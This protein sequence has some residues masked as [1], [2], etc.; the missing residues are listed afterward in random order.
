MV[1]LNSVRTE[2]EYIYNYTAIG[3]PCHR[4]IH[5]MPRKTVSALVNVVNYS[6]YIGNNDITSYM[7]KLDENKCYNRRLCIAVAKVVFRALVLALC[8]A[9]TIPSIILPQKSP[10]NRSAEQGLQ[11]G[12]VTVLECNLKPSKVTGIIVN[13]L[14]P[15]GD[16]P[17]PSV[18]KV[19][20]YITSQD[21]LVP[22]QKNVSGFYEGTQSKRSKL[23][24]LEKYMLARSNVTIAIV[25]SKES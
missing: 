25:A 17:S 6:V 22:H 9:F 2:P 4:M 18:T 8:I 24:M 14:Q 7:R 3:G 15:Y 13:D 1:S 21:R 19:L 11:T 20:L 10:Q 23:D 16:L 5:K 12:V